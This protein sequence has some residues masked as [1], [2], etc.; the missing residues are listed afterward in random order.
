MFRGHFHHLDSLRM[1][2]PSDNHSFVLV[3][4]RHFCTSKTEVMKSITPSMPGYV[5]AT[6]RSVGRLWCDNS[7]GLTCRD[8]TMSMVGYPKK[9]MI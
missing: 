2:T 7:I 4:K 1:R 3:N 8:E 5:P 9:K 6:Q